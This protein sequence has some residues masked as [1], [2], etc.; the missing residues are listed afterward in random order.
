[1]GVCGFGLVLC[2]WLVGVLFGFVVVCVGSIWRVC[3]GVFV[4]FGG[5]WGVLVGGRLSCIRGV[6]TGCCGRL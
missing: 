2:V 5:F 1:V 3:R 6:G 4:G